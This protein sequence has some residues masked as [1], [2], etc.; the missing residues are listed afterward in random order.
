MKV[1]KVPNSNNWCPNPYD[2]LNNEIRQNDYFETKIANEAGT[3]SYNI[4][5]YSCFTS[6]DNSIKDLWD[7]SFGKLNPFTFSRTITPGTY[8]LS[9]TAKTAENANNYAIGANTKHT[10]IGYIMPIIK[11]KEG[12]LSASWDYYVSTNSSFDNTAYNYVTFTKEL[13]D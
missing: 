11:T 3:K 4:V 2:M 7:S 8:L 1:T 13:L 9:L 5:N 10:I 6:S 12:A